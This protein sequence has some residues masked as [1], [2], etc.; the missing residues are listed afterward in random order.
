ME[1]GVRKVAKSKVAQFLALVRD[2]VISYAK[3]AS[4]GGMLDSSTNED[5]DTAAGNKPDQFGIGHAR[6][7]LAVGLDLCYSEEIVARVAAMLV[8][9]IANAG[10]QDQAKKG[11]GDGQ[12]PEDLVLTPSLIG[13]VEHGEHEDAR[14]SDGTGIA[15]GAGQLPEDVMDLP[16]RAASDVAL[17]KQAAHLV[18]NNG[19]SHGGDEAG[20]DG[21]RDKLEQ[22][23]QLEEAYNHAVDA[24]HQ[25][26]GR[27]NFGRRPV[28]LELINDLGRQKAN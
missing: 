5:S 12:E 27:R 3:S 16:S 23:A 4:N 13:L 15:I 19:Y 11:T 25:R 21:E 6:G 10:E 20:K 26:H 2:I 8:Y 1:E 18:E 17:T 7:F 24:H 22:K 28:I 9:G 14:E